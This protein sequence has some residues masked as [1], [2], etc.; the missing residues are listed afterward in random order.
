MEKNVRI[1]FASGLVIE[2]MLNATTYIVDEK[3]AFPANI[4][5]VT[6]EDED[7]STVYHNAKIVE[8]YS[9]DGKYRFTITEATEIERRFAEIED[10]LCDLSKE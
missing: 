9:D 5:D 2:A 8:A 10:A 7:G 1:I 4:E 3:P 6:V